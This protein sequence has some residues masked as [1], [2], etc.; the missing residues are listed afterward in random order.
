VPF[1]NKED[2]FFKAANIH[3]AEAYLGRLRKL[4]QLPPEIATN[5]AE[6][7]LALRC[8]QA[9][10]GAGFDDWSSLT[11][12]FD[13]IL[14][15]TNADDIYLM[16]APAEALSSRAKTIYQNGDYMRARSLFERAAKLAPDNAET[17]S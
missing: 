13:D 16:A 12:D 2:G 4:N 10:V 17:A 8:I 1:L 11:S 14:A 3:L 5:A 7:N 9:A 15:V 6:G